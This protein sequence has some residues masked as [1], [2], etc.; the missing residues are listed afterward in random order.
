MTSP[1]TPRPDLPGASTRPQTV[2]PSV[3][4]AYA[5]AVLAVLG[6]VIG[7][8][9]VV[10]GFLSGDGPEEQGRAEFPGQVQ[11]ESPARDEPLV[12]Y[13]ERSTLSGDP[14]L[15]GYLAPIVTRGDGEVPVDSEAKVERHAGMSTEMIP[16]GLFEAVGGE[17]TVTVD[18]DGSTDGTDVAIVVADPNV[19]PTG[20]RLMIWGG[21]VG[22]AMLLVGAVMVV[23]VGRARDRARVRG[24]V[25]SR[26]GA[27]ADGSP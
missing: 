17:Y 1:A 6:I 13:L 10:M 4:W 20:D 18:P 25:E 15:P 19:D 26:A 7:V 5:G 2:K 12:I 27:V 21:V 22:A 9:L 3:L 16:I 8:G 24:L 14:G 23:T 11:F